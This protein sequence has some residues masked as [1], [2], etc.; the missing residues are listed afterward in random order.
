[1]K[2]YMAL[3]LTMVVAATSLTA[4]GGGS[5]EQPNDDIAVIGLSQYGQHGS[6]DNCRIGFLEGLEESGLVEGV[7]YKIDY[8]NAGFDDNVCTQIAQNFIAQDVDLMSAVATPSAM[9]CFAA[10]E[11][12]DIPVVFTAVADPEIAGVAEGNITGTSDKLPIEGQLELMRAIH[13][14]AKTI[15][16]MYTTSEINSVATIEEYKE[17]C[18]DYDFELVLVGVSQQAEVMQATDNLIAQKVDIFCNLTDNNV[19]GVL[20]S[21]LEKTNAAGIPVYGSEIEQVKIGCIA[22]AG[23]DYV[24]LGRRSGAMAAQILRGEATATEIPYEAD[25]AYEVYINSEVLAAMNI[26][27]SDELTADA[28]DVA[29]QASAGEAK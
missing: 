9:A 15:G 7:D 6:L 16:M 18:P 26:I 19:V 3:A 13:P 12:K 5:D 14:D 27:L 28:I 10:A 25:G 22:S 23:L 29:G 4:C 24:A 20:P 8:Q 1:M 17:K 2:K 21:I 11:E